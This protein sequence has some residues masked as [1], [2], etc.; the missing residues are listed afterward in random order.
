MAAVV[1]DIDELIVINCTANFEDSAG[2]DRNRPAI[3]KLRA[4]NIFG[5]PSDH[6]L[7]PRILL[8]TK[9]IT[10]TITNA[11]QAPTALSART[12][13]RPTKGRSV[14]WMLIMSFLLV[15]NGECA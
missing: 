15:S 9:Q 14:A 3:H 1:V 4:F 12:R 8:E 5:C 11:A 10:L 13:G 2:L 7:I 6:D